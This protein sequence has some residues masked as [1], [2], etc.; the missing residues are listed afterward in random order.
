VVQLI[1]PKLGI[2]YIAS[3][4]K[5]YFEPPI[6]FTVIDGEQ[7]ENILR[8][9][10]QEK[11]NI[12]GIT[13]DTLQF[14]DVLKIATRIK[15]EFRD[16]PII[17]GGVHVS[18]LPETLPKFFD[19]GVRGEGE[20]TM[21]ELIKCY[22]ENHSFPEDKLKKIDGIAFHH[23]KK[24][25]ITR[26]RR[27]IQP[28][29]K[30]PH[31]TRDIF[32][33]K[34]YLK[35]IYHFPDTFGRG[36]HLITARGCLY[37][38]VFCN[39]PRS[40]GTIRFHSA[41]YVVE[42]MQELIENYNVD[43]IN[44]LDDLFAASRKRLVEIVKLIRKEKINEKVRF[45]CQMRAN[46]MNDEMAKILKKMNMIFL[47]YGFESG[48]EKVLNFLKKGQVTLEQNIKAAKIARKYG[49]KSA[50]NFMAGTPGETVE[51]LEK[52]YKFILDIPLDDMNIFITTPYPGTELWN[53]LKQKGIASVFTDWGKLSPLLYSRD[54]ILSDIETEEFKKI[55]YKLKFAASI[56][57]LQQKQLLYVLMHLGL[58]TA[59]FTKKN[60][61]YVPTYLSVLRDFMRRYL[62]RMKRNISSFD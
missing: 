24:V 16:T 49:F 27:F 22:Y 8:R 15:S 41:E 57:P 19:I 28:L 37:K 23:K 56:S 33:M 59:Q 20:Q 39:S 53:Y 47:G 52:S 18:S 42:E 50:T 38:C 40:W 30:I 2:A 29:D 58:K 55:F 45:G 3:Y 10:G 5:E 7:G 9:L 26:R 17:L 6:K 31:P 46:L 48:S 11:P 4:L 44:I 34:Y 43:T 60:P 32:N 12:I 61:K 14:S 1:Y 51:D 54:N 62:P 36:L 21:L 35:K 25:I 13:S